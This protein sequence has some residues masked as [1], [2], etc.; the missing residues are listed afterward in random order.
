MAE[1]VEVRK[2]LIQFAYDRSEHEHGELS[3]TWK[4]LDSKAQSTAT[5]AGVFIAA[6]FAFVRNTALNLDQT[7][8]L[9]LCGSVVF[10]VA[11]ICTA[12]CAMKIRP[13]S[14]PLSGFNAEKTVDDI[15]A[16][17]ETEL[18]LR[19]QILLKETVHQWSTVNKELNNIVKAKGQ[20][21]EWSQ[22][23]LFVAAITVAVMTLHAIFRV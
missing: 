22:T 3:E 18:P 14:M 1:P 8:K 15:L 6:A 11:S 13:V 17:E 2:E 16:Q 19:L 9:L 5:L 23:F 7:E 12:V 21:I 20:C 10:L 4:H